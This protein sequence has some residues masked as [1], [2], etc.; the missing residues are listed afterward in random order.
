MKDNKGQEGGGLQ[1]GLLLG[2]S[3]VLPLVQKRR[4]VGQLPLHL[5]S[6]LP[7]PIPF[8]FS[9]LKQPCPSSSPL[10]KELDLHGYWINHFSIISIIRLTLA[11]LSATTT[12]WRNGF[13]SLEPCPLSLY[14]VCA[15]D[16]VFLGVLT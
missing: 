11:P 15:V 9:C 2:Q 13:G 14:S 6:L 3:Q 7:A 8:D 12:S 16:F 5:P 1:K 4:S 10:S